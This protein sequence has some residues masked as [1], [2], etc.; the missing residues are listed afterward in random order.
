MWIVCREG[1][2]CLFRKTNGACLSD[3]GD[4]N[5]SRICHLILDFLCDFSEG[6]LAVRRGEMWGFID[7]DGREVIPCQYED[8]FAY[9][10]GLARVMKNNF[11]GFIDKSGREVI[12][13]IYCDAGVFSEGLAWVKK[14]GKCG[15]LDKT[16]KVVIPFVYYGAHDFSGGIARVITVDPDV[17]DNWSPS[18]IDKTGKI[19]NPE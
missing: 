19:V 17:V 9:H 14:E 7:M 2:R 6:L 16:G 12:P 5:L 1:E 15:F 18:Y 10:E 3:D 4:F 13:C 8:V 11:F